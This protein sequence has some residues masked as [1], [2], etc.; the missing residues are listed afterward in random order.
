M[1]AESSIRWLWIVL[2]LLVSGSGNSSLCHHYL[3]EL[4][5]TC[6]L[7]FFS[8]RCYDWIRSMQLGPLVNKYNFKLYVFLFIFHGLFNGAVSVSD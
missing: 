5:E 6:I 2:I 1:P 4:L 7:Y 3:E 8:T